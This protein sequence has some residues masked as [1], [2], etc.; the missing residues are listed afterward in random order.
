MLQWSNLSAFAQILLAWANIVAELIK[1][2]AG[3]GEG[4]RGWWGDE[5]SCQGGVKKVF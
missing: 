5:R 2:G 4:G 3:G 1:E